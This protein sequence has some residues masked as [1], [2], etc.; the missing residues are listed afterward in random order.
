[1]KHPA[2]APLL[3]SSVLAAAGA[4]AQPVPAE[5]VSYPQTIFHNGV[6]LTMDTD[7]GDFTIVQAVAVRDGRIL[8]VGSDQQV[9]RLAGPATRKVDLNKKALMPG[10]VDTHVHPNRYAVRNYFKE[11]APEYQRLLR[12]SGSM[13]E[14]KDRAKALKDLEAV[15]ERS[16][17]LREWVLI[18]GGDTLSEQNPVVRSITRQDL[19]RIS[20][21]RPLF[22]NGGSWEGL[23]NTKALEALF[24][25][26]GRDLPG[27]MKDAN[28]EP[29]GFVTGAP[30]FILEEDIIPAP[31]A[32]ALAPL[33]AKELRERWAPVGTTT[34][35]TRL[36]A[37][38]IR[39]YGV[40]DVR[41]ELPLRM[42]YGHE[43]GRWNPTFDRDLK[44]NV[45][46]VIGHGSDMLW[47]NAITVAP[48]D[49]SPGTWDICTSYPKRNPVEGDFF[50]KGDCRW[51]RP[52]DMTRDTVR[53]LVREG[54]RIANIHTYGDEGNLKAIELFKELGV[55]RAD[56][57]G[58]DH[59][60]MFNADLIKKAGELGIYWSVAAQKFVEDPEVLAQV[61][62][63]EETDRWAFPLKE[64]VDAGSKVTYESSN[65]PDIYEDNYDPA[66]A[67]HKGGPFF[68]MQMW[69]TRRDGKG[70]QW[71]ARHAL[72]RKTVLRMMTRWGAEYVLRE[73]VLGTIEPGKFADLIVVDRNP[74]DPA[75]PDDRLSELRVLMTMVGGKVVYAGP[76]FSM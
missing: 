64:L 69:V 9:L 10:I 30:A 7:R 75:I 14:W 59:T 38:H 49:G 55:D 12:G 1:M 56:R 8:A 62:G 61:Y 66:K 27:I 24:K 44:R 52:G 18:S 74:L 71:G 54:F 3:L 63:R 13:R 21:E 57:F 34:I 26:H 43:A 31:P 2:L 76:G 67:T 15:V 19:D 23:A 4:G 72:D 45:G 40:L 58:L 42:A 5:L 32:E 73:K 46:T 48:P 36:N 51:D 20:P 70:N 60:A 6:V 33:F 16:D 65:R 17:P 68:D 28:G 39:A 37:N 11:L 29:T 25:L 50:P 47:M 53:Q 22:I 35:S 41:G